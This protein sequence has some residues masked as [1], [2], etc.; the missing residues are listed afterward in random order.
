MALGFLR[1]ENEAGNLIAPNGRREMMGTLVLIEKNLQ[2]GGI[3][4]HGLR[5]DIDECA[6]PHDNPVQ[7]HGPRIEGMGPI[8]HSPV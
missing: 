6:A 8:G 5:H 2:G 7:P 1:A 4:E 3:V